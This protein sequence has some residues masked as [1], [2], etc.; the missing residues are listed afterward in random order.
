MVLYFF[1]PLGGISMSRNVRNVQYLPR[2][3]W[4]PAVLTPS[5]AAYHLK[6]P[7]SL[8]LIPEGTKVIR[9]PSIEAGH[10]RSFLIDLLAV[11]AR[12]RRSAPAP[13][14][15]P[16]RTE[17]T[18]SAGSGR[19]MGRL[20]SARRLLFFPDDQ[21]GWLPFAVVAGLRAHRADPFDAIY[22]T[23]SPITSHLVAGIIKRWTGL[24]WIAEF[25][26]PWLGNALAAPLPWIHRRLRVK[27][28][29]WIVRTADRVVGVSPGITE[30]Y[31]QR[32]P[33]APEMVTITSGYDRGE[34]RPPVRRDPADD[35]YR[36]VYTGTLDRPEEL[37][38]FLEGVEGLLTRRPELAARLTIDFFGAVSDACRATADRFT[39]GIAGGAVH[40]R[41][42]VPRREAMD[43]LASADAALILLG[44]GPGMGLFIGG[45]LF[46]YLGQDRQIL[47]MLPQGDSRDILLSL[48]WGVVCDPDPADV[49]RAIER[50][51]ELPPPDRAADPDGRFD[52]VTLAGQLARSLDE[53]SGPS[54][55]DA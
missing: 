10:V 32:Y 31:R 18:G 16:S 28:E 2:H 11:L 12:I 55:D 5:N 52:R 54:G 47:A 13:A 53:I 9:V 41:G 39:L 25:R 24:P 19:G 33:G 27:L 7:S 15:A 44:A 23:S 17:S 14:A 6:D 1:P 8:D 50:L 22:S 21:I 30:L 34:R 51:I 3:G 4:R 43:A 26:D 29:R 48:D 46:D 40:Y 45:K 38:I 49:E 35:R 42:F 20:E 37:R 36:I